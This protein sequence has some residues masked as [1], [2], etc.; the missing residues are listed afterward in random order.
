M[1]SNVRSCMF[2]SA[3][4]IFLVF[5]PAVEAGGLGIGPVRIEI[6]NAI[7]SLEYSH[8]LFIQST[9]E[10][11]VN[12]S[13]Y[14]E[15]NCSEWI[16]LY[17][18]DDRYKAITNI[19]MPSLSEV[20]LLSKFKIPLDATAGSYLCTIYV[21]QAPEQGE[22][23]QTLAIRV[24]SIVK[25]NVSGEELPKG[26]VRGI[27]IN[28]PE[29][30]SPLRIEII[31]QNTGN[32]TANPRIKAN[33]TKDGIVID[34]IIYTETIVEPGKTETIVIE[35]DTTGWELGEYKTP[36]K[37]FLYGLIYDREDLGFK[38]LE[39]GSVGSDPSGGS[40]GGGASGSSSDEEYNETETLK[41]IEVTI[42]YEGKILEV[43]IPEKIN[44]GD[45]VKTEIIFS[46]TGEAD[47]RAKAEAEIYSEGKFVDVIQGDEILL[48]A[49]ETRALTLYFKPESA[50]E[51]L[52]KANV[53]YEGQEIEIDTITFKVSGSSMPTGM[54]VLAPGLVILGVII[55]VV[56]IV[57]Y[58]KRQKQ[59]Y[60]WRKRWGH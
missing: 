15:G 25:I 1:K 29:V 35:K 24:K 20:K 16:S 28:N 2:L 52:I 51:Y 53:V 38:I 54:F 45:I 19:T 10:N 60:V 8:T 7:R 17:N 22:N 55:A 11:D 47:I 36:M 26:E 9:F 21:Q 56:L 12:L 39:Q 41:I 4:A 13:L 49:G 44:L 6:N 59:Q 18:Y 3:I 27:A 23:T 14:V 40:S 30:N 57:W 46:N 33:I 58:K 37:V 42:S 43:K 48:K 50:G 32:V 5:L 34:E 31:F